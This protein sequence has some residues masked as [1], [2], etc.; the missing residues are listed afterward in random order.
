MTASGTAAATI[1]GSATLPIELMG[2]ASVIGWVVVCLGVDGVLTSISSPMEGIEKLSISRSIV[3]IA[4]SRGL[5]MLWYHS[6]LTLSNPE[7]KE[8]MDSDCQLTAEV[9]S[10][11]SGSG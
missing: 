8:V 7:S 10:K 9:G 11:A 2:S 4:E 5:S 6:S 1:A 3:S